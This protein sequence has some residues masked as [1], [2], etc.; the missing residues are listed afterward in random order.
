M[1]LWVIVYN[2]IR[3]KLLNETIKVYFTG[4]LYVVWWSTESSRGSRI[5]IV[6]R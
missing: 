4:K 6:G 3:G 5:V 1:V 2:D